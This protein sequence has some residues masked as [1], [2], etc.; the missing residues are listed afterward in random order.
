MTI[1]DIVD[2]EELRNQLAELHR[3]LNSNPDPHPPQCTSSA[4]AQNRPSNKQPSPKYPQ[5][6]SSTIQTDRTGPRRGLRDDN[7]ANDLTMDTSFLEKRFR[8]RLETDIQVM[9]APREHEHTTDN[10]RVTA[11]SNIHESD[12]RKLLPSERQR[13]ELYS[14]SYSPSN[15]SSVEEID[16]G[17]EKD[18]DEDEDEEQN[19]AELKGPNIPR[20][21][22]T[23]PL[24]QPQQQRPLNPTSSLNQRRMEPIE[25]RN[26]GRPPDAG[27]ESGGELSFD[28][29]VARARARREFGA[30]Q[31][32]GSG[33]PNGAGGPV[34][35]A[36]RLDHGRDLALEDLASPVRYDF[37]D[38]QGG[39]HQLR[40]GEQPVGTI[41]Q[42]PN[43]RVRPHYP[44]MT[45]EEEM[46]RLNMVTKAEDR[47]MEL[48]GSLGEGQAVASLLGT[49]KG[50]IRQLKA[51]KRSSMSTVKDLKKDL[52]QAQRELQRTRKANEKLSKAKPSTTSHRNGSKH[53]K[54]TSLDLN[55]ATLRPKI[56]Q[57]QEEKEQERKNAAIQREKDRAERDVR[58]LQKQLDTLEKQKEAMQKRERL[59]AEEEADLLFLIESESDDEDEEEEGS[60]SESESEIESDDDDSFRIQSESAVSGRSDREA[61]FVDTRARRNPKAMKRSSSKGT[62]TTKVK[63][64]QRHRTEVDN[65]R[66]R[67]RTRQAAQGAGSRSKSAH[68]YTHH[69]VDNVVHI[70]RLVYYG[71]ADME[72]MSSSRPK[73]IKPRL[74]HSA[75]R[76][77]DQFADRHEDAH[78]LNI[79]GSHR[80]NDAGFS[81]Y[82]RGSPHQFEKSGTSKSMLSRSF[83][84]QRI[85]ASQHFE[86]PAEELSPSRPHLRRQQTAPH[87]VNWEEQGQQSIGRPVPAQKDG[88]A[89]PL[90]RPGP[91]ATSTTQGSARMVTRVQ[92]GFSLRSAGTH[93]LTVPL[94]NPNSQRKKIS[95]DLQRILSL[96]KTHDPRRCTVCCNGGDGRDHSTH[97]QDDQQQQQQQQQPSRPAIKI[98]GRPVFIRHKSAAATT[99]R[100][101]IIQPS[102]SSRAGRHAVKIN[103]GYRDAVSD[104]ELSVSSVS[105][106]SDSEVRGKKATARN[107]SRESRDHGAGVGG[108]SY[109]T[110]QRR[111][112]SQPPQAT[113]TNVSNT[114]N[115][116]NDHDDDD[117]DDEQHPPEWKL[118]VTLCK[119]DKEVQQLRK[120]HLDLSGKLERLGSSSNLQ[121]ASSMVAAAADE[122]G[123]L[124]LEEQEKKRQQRRQLRLQLQRVVDSLEEKAEEILSLQHYLLEQQ[125][126]QQ[127]QQ[128]E[129]YEQSESV[130]SE[131]S[132]LTRKTRKPSAV[133]VEDD[134]GQDGDDLGVGERQAPGGRGLRVPERFKHRT[135][136]GS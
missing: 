19:T 17:V 101:T 50:M 22:H 109:P 61:P 126:R 1:R 84:G 42:G 73:V 77:D 40:V 113:E 18:D 74:H 37:D 80:I 66:A 14:S 118:H 136:N 62:S 122:T 72:D 93:E 28:R 38:T 8:A 60:E 90:Y 36:S 120:S 125:Q 92:H 103:D 10:G 134:V 112:Q 87:E 83:P 31:D 46:E 44:T 96:L 123:S 82:R 71:D 16:E 108:L 104:S 114:N 105:S 85:H 81:S 111:S 30:S 76:L 54:G 45:P 97:H 128:Q 127:Q 58:A 11:S 39:Q 7:V 67:D 64:V 15:F 13:R 135:V 24:S 102:S 49:L 25:H 29:E 33:R 41:E 2:S 48:A 99:I 110:R 88:E 78:R 35:K 5:A 130:V 26:N 47:F 131:S 95:I 89:Y 69:P 133:A 129:S 9:E 56:N 12:Y 107:E 106:V 79:G 94:K 43:R 27:Y 91:Q 23:P 100:S 119:L 53:D 34:V 57:S 116:N 21:V 124:S 98:D 51:E 115:T 132:R 86:A 6:L 70:H 52:K 121:P 20:I 3:S 59:R 117:E 63:E 75:S 68:P 55:N 4:Q 32:N 65:H